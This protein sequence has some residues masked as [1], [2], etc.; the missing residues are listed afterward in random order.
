MSFAR[1][2]LALTLLVSFVSADAQPTTAR[3]GFLWAGTANATRGLEDALQQGLAESGYS[4]GKNLVIEHRWADGRLERLPQLAAELVR[5]NVDLIMASSVASALAAKRATTRIPIVMV[6]VSD[7]VEVGLV[8]NLARPGGN[9]TGFSLLTTRLHAKRLQLLKEL[10][11]KATRVAVLWNSANPGRAP[12][13]KELRAAA[14]VLEMRL[15]SY[16]V[17]TAADVP[18][19]LAAMRANQVDAVFSVG[20]PLFFQERRRIVDEATRLRIPAIYDHSAYVEAG[21]LI[22]YGAN[23][24]ENYRRSAVYVAKILRGAKP[25]DLPVEEPTTIELLIN[26]KTARTLG[27]MLPTALLQRA[28]GLI[29]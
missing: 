26:V 10:L 18:T 15:D 29:E 23:L 14:S 13:W 4:E 9:I 8:G 27:V 2:A 11:P 22:S 25:G 19:V 17:R 20:D 16:E 7:A 24:R 28:D 1:L 5:A 21:G 6:G 3:V 12:D